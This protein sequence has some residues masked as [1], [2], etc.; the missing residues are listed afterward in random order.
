MKLYYKITDLINFFLH[1][2]FI[3]LKILFLFLHFRVKFCLTSTY[4][5]IIFYKIHMLNLLLLKKVNYD[6]LKC[7]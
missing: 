7:Q 4:S 3:K 2:N 6:I 1:S 5:H